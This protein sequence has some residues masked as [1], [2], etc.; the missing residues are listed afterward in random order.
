MR[1]LLADGAA[2][3]EWHARARVADRDLAVLSAASRIASGEM[4]TPT[5]RVLPGGQR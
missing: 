4:S 3:E 2:V 1:R 5:A